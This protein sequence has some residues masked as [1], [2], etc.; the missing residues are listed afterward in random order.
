MC[1]V[2]FVATRG[3]ARS[4]PQ[5][6]ILTSGAQVAVLVVTAEGILYEYAVRNLRAPQ[7]PACALEQESFLLRSD[8]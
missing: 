3:L 2:G 7:G 6:A 4:F 5:A 1:W 8:S